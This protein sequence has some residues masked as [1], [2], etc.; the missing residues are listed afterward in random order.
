MSGGAAVIGD[1]VLATADQGHVVFCQLVPWQCDY[2]K[3]QSNVKRTFRCSSCLVSRV[4]GNMGVESSTPI[5]ARFNSP[6]EAGNKTDKRWL[7]GLYLD[8]PEEWDN[9]YRSFRW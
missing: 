7:E 9:P 6:V 4:L 1:G 3:E 8:Q 2:S 5:L